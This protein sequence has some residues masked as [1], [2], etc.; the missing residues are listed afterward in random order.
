MKI[1]K[2]CIIN[3]PFPDWKNILQNNNEF[4]YFDNIVNIDISDY[5]I[6]AIS[7]E[8]YKLY[9]NFKNNIFIND[10]QNIEILNNKSL[11]GNYMKN[12]FPEFI[13]TIYYYNYDDIFYTN[14][15]LEKILFISK[16]NIGCASSGIKI[17]YNIF[18]NPYKNCI[19]SKYITHTIYY[20]GHFLVLNGI[21][22]NKI[23]FYKNKQNKQLIIKGR[24]TNYEITDKLNID[25]MIFNKIFIDLKYSG[26]ACA[27]FIILNNNI[28]IF[29]INPRPGGSL[30][31]DNK[32]FNIFIKTLIEITNI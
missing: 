9:N 7:I 16:P 6:I 18:D 27:D 25:D 29:E 17:G 28:I 11:F 24:I 13:P 2:Y 22:I 8:D 20:S 14:K 1:N 3:T 10:F 23:Y 15:P 4:T 31:Y 30:I 19:I 12:K 32:Y 21:I 26:F 5:K